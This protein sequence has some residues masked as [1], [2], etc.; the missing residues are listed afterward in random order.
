MK[1]LI[2]VYSKNYPI[3]Q[4][5]LNITFNGHKSTSGSPP[6]PVRPIDGRSHVQNAIKDRIVVEGILRCIRRVPSGIFFMNLRIPHVSQIK[7]LR[8]LCTRL[9]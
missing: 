6:L 3:D 8:I 1:I 7:V 5:T 2:Y 9:S 4:N